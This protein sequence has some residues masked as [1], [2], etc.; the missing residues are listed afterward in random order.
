MR[1]TPL[2]EFLNEDLL[3]RATCGRPE[4]AA[5]HPC[6]S[7]RHGRFDAFLA[8]LEDVPAR[9]WW[10]GARNLLHGRSPS[11]RRGRFVTNGHARVH[12]DRRISGPLTEAYPDAQRTGG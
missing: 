5:Q 12:C 4:P 7:V 6:R 11:I 8:R 2:Y 1:T 9:A 3:L 10:R